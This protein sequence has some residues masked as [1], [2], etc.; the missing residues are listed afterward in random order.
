M[1][2]WIKNTNNE[3]SASLTLVIVTFSVIMLH[4]V[5]S[6]F[7]NP[8]G[9]AIAPFKAAEAMMVLGPLLGLYWGRRNTDV[10]DK[11]IDLKHG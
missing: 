9:I 2:F 3:K 6:I 8:F 11:E 5:A 1:N 10:K 4:M 7:V